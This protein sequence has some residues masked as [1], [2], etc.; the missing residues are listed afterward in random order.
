MAG[1][2]EEGAGQAATSDE[3]GAGSKNRT[4]RGEWQP[5]LEQLMRGAVEQGKC[6]VA[7]RRV[8]VHAF[9]RQ[10]CGK[11]TSPAEKWTR[12]RLCC[13]TGQG[14]WHAAAKVE[15]IGGGRIAG[16]FAYNV[17]VADQNPLE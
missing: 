2:W 8:Q 7:R 10:L 17:D 15:T 1:E 14:E 16:A 12:P 5:K 6:K 11:S 4:G 9:G 3:W 13:R